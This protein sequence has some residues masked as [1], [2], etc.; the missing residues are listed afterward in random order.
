MRELL[1]ILIQLR[2]ESRMIAATKRPP[3]GQEAF[4]LGYVQ[5]KHAGYEDAL[6]VIQNWADDQDKSR[7][8]L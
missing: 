2:D 8:N 4:T 1:K 3:P 5:G 6:K 7:D